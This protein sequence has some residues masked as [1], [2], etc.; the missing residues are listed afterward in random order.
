MKL[1]VVESSGKAS[2]MLDFLRKAAPSEEWKVI[3]CN[4]HFA[5]LSPKSLSLNPKKGFAPSWKSRDRKYSKIVRNAIEK[6]S[7]VYA[8]TDFGPDG[9]A[10]A[11][12]IFM[13]AERAGKPFF[14]LRLPVLDVESFKEAISSP[15]EVDRPV[16]DSFLAR[17][18]V[19]R[20]VRFKL[21]PVMMKRLGSGALER[22]PALLLTELARRER[23][24]RRYQPEENWTV[25]ALLENGSIAVSGPVESED[26]ANE[27]VRRCKAAE[28]AY[29]SAPEQELPP[30]PFTTSSLLRFLSER[31]GYLPSQSMKLCEMLYG[32]GYITQPYTD[33][34]FVADS[35]LESVRAYIEV[36]FGEEF[37]H[38]KKRKY[39]ADGSSDRLEAIRPTNIVV[40]PSKSNIRGDLRTVYQAIWFSAV[41]SQGLFALL[42]KQVCNYTFPESTDVV[43]SAHGVR[44]ASSGWHQLSSRLFLVPNQELMEEGLSVLEASTLLTKIAPPLR[45]T[46]ASLIAWLDET[47]VGRPHNYA[48]SISY[49][50]DV[51]H[52][53]SIQGRLRITDRG[54]AILTFLRKAVPDLIDPDFQAETE[55]EIDSV[56][57]GD[58][59]Y[60][61]FALDYW[62]WVLDAESKMEKA[63][64]RP[65]FHS[66]GGGKLRIWI[67][68]D[69]VWAFS[70][71]EDWWTP[72]IFD[73]RGRFVADASDE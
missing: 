62:N 4:N 8:A 10:I 42:E 52:A 43:F 27:I 23:K 14:R 38:G 53:E 19:D 37:L 16:F 21:G 5:G 60:Q 36:T 9:E 56:A 49:L 22:I 3:S 7:A 12:Q 18:A 20:F 61:K 26:A 58:L 15:G 48:A 65:K 34:F 71:K 70:R 59:T 63:S 67:D 31:Y 64:L 45:H 68:K 25:R 35:F 47:A 44:V 2:L 11:Y 55:E 17:E 51:G 66:P 33:S 57:A 30:P 29:T 54:E 32:L 40:A 69:R 24:V 46:A 13:T 1:L 73:S 39:V 41:A 50:L 28:P 72:V 6:A